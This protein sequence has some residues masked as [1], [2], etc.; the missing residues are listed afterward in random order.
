LFP[1]GCCIFGEK[2]LKN[3][4]EKECRELLGRNIKRFR[5]QRGI[6][7]LDLALEIDISAT[8]MSDIEKG[9]TWVSAKTLT[10]IAKALHIEVFELLKPGESAVTPSN[11]VSEILEK[12]ISEVNGII[13]QSIENSVAP[14]ISAIINDSLKKFVKQ[15]AR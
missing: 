1:I 6:S 14:A 3:L 10:E 15:M 7:Q 8:F 11:G 5:N 13:T 12:Y 2:I 4:T 9:R